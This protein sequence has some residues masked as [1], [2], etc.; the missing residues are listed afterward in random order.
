M[1]PHDAG[2]DPSLFH[3]RQRGE[4][5]GFS[6]LSGL[7][8][9]LAEREAELDPPAAQQVRHGVGGSQGESRHRLESSIRLSARSSGGPPLVK[10]LALARSKNQD[11]RCAQKSTKC[12]DGIVSTAF[13]S[14]CAFCGLSGTS[15]ERDNP[16]MTLD[17]V[18]RVE[19]PEG[20]ELDLPLA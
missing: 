11:R 6:G 4:R 1:Q 5:N 16:G 8:L 9:N 3:F 18:R 7:F 10:Q 17:T 19:T 15:G 13:R 20:V 2:I 12:A 14:T